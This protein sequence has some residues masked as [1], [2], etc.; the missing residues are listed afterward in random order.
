MAEPKQIAD[1]ELLQKYTKF[2]LRL[3]ANFEYFASQIRQQ[4]GKQSQL[5]ENVFS[6]YRQALKS[7]FSDTEM[8]E[9]KELEKEILNRMRGAK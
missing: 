7:P 8:D 6:S 1:W 3:G 9:A 5:L 4:A 2:Y